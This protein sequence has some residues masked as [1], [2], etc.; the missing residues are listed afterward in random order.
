M[1]DWQAL[2]GRGSRAADLALWF[3]AG[4]V[5]LGLHLG[6]AAWYLQSSPI[7][8]A[9][10][11]PPPAVMVEF[12]PVPEAIETEANE[13]SPDQHMADAQAAAAAMEPL[14]EPVPLNPVEKV[15]APVPPEDVIKAEEPE[16]TIKTDVE[17]AEVVLP[18]ARPKL[19]ETKPKQEP[20]KT[21]RQQAQKPAKPTM[22]AKVQVNQS[23][24]NA[25]RQTT[26]DL[27]SGVAPAQWRSLLMAH[28]ERRKRYPAGARSRG[29]QGVVYV[30]FRIDD[31][32]NVLAA[33]LARSSGF[34]ELDQEVLSLVRRASPV[35]A[36]PAG[37]ARTITAPVLFEARR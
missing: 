36:P 8:P 28:L 2:S 16:E 13:I 33:S 4:L 29:E 31:A 27:F 5:V 24:R 11:A 34:A 22:E 35:P 12:A 32:G 6:A 25:A 20:A 19:L 7:M 3:G 37:V 14:S 10:D 18:Q 1:T 30:R 21:H 9:N 23:S 26:A 15:E 17:Q